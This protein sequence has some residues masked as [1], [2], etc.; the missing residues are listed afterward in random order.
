MSTRRPTRRVTSIALGF[1]MLGGVL[2]ATAAPASAVDSCPTGIYTMQYAPGLDN[3]NG[4]A[5]N[6]PGVDRNGGFYN[7]QFG[8]ACERP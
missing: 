7:S 8:N 3:G 5:V 4:P 1:M 6:N 2:V